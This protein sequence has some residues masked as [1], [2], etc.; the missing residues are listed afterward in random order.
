MVP[1]RPEAREHVLA[2]LGGEERPGLL[3]LR[4]AVL[5]RR[6]GL[7]GD[8]ARRPHTVVYLRPAGRRREAFGAGRPEP[9][10]GWL[11]AR[12]GEITLLAPE[13]WEPWVRSALGPLEPRRSEVRTWYDPPTRDPKGPSPAPVRRLGPED[14]QAFLTIAPEW[15]LLGWGGFDDLIRHGAAFGVPFLDGFVAI[16]WIFDQTA[17]FD[18]L[19]VF[20]VPRFRRLGLARAVAR[21]LIR[22]SQKE[23]A[24]SPLWSAHAENA[25]SHALALSLGFEGPNSEMLLSWPASSSVPEPG[26]MI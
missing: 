23:R 19:G 25:A 1:L 11:A 16:A 14:R 10:A 5:F 17:R 8:N 15:A 24:K 6:P 7:W 4:H 2:K 22:T 26:R 21:S 9:A 18:A 13:E 3:A 20:T 12:E